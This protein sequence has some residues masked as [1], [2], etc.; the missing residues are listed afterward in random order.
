MRIADETLGD[1]MRESDL[2]ACK[3]DVLR[4]AG[5]F[6]INRLKSLVIRELARELLDKL[7]TF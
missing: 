5:I 3:M 1:V 2:D 6:D 4:K 7:P